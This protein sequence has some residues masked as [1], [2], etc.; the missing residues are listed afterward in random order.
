MKK[1]EEIVDKPA[2]E[3]PV[4]VKDIPSRQ[5]YE[6]MKKEKHLEEHNKFKS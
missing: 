1:K 2:K 4:N 5:A 3:K 6:A